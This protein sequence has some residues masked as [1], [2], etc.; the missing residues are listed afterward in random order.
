MSEKRRRFSPEEKVAILRRHFLEKVPISDLCQEHQLH[1]NIFYQ[2]QKQFFE[3]GAVA[4]HRNNGSDERK[5][6]QQIELLREKLAHKD[7]V[8][9]EIMD[10]HVALK[11]GL[12]EDWKAHG[13]NPM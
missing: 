3:N 10:A 8:I 2:W 1:P 7:S 4:F 12:S 5:L 6:Q 9:A 13:R 11:K